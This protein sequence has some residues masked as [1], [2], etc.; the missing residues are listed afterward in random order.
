MAARFITAGARLEFARELRSLDIGGQLVQG[1]RAFLGIE[2]FHAPPCLFE[3]DDVLLK[4]NKWGDVFL[5]PGFGGELF[6]DRAATAR[7]KK[8]VDFAGLAERGR[9]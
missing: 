7:K 4:S 8:V 3:P 5:F 9:S 2:S 6:S 1:K